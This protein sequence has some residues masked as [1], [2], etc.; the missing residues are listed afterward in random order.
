MHCEMKEETLLLLRESML[1]NTSC[2]MEINEN[3]F[4][5]PKGN[6]TEIAFLRWLQDAEVDVHGH[7]QGRQAVEVNR[8]ALNSY[9]KRSIVAIKHPNMDDTIRIYVKGAPEVILGQCAYT[10]NQHGEKIELDQDC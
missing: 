5:V 6:D 9:T 7:M 3:S 10:F 8:I 2:H 1:Y 4:Y